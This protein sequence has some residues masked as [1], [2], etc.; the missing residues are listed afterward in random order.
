MV[1]VRVLQEGIS[2]SFLPCGG[3]L[4]AMLST[5]SQGPRRDDF[6]S[7]VM[8]GKLCLPSLLPYRSGLQDEERGEGHAQRRHQAWGSVC[9]CIESSL[10]GQATSLSIRMFFLGGS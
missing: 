1:V 2:S 3:G 8:L 10:Y 5:R 6:I 7:E 9:V 4:C